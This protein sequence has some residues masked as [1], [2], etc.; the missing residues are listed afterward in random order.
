MDWGGWATF[1]LV[2][3]VLLTAMMTGAQLGGLTRMDLPLMLG[4]LFVRDPDQARVAGVFVHLANGQV[5]ALFYAATFARVGHAGL[6][7]GAGLGALHALVA[8]TLLVPLLPGVHRHMASE[9]AG[10]EATGAVLEPPGL[11]GRNY[12]RETALVA[13]VAHVAY[14]AL[15]GLLLKP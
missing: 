4:T 8:L 10:P 1:G 15:L 12:G 2:A 7:L 11:F 9:R 5:F 14:G 3:T 6:L 13:A